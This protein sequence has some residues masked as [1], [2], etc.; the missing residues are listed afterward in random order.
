MITKNFKRKIAMSLSLVLAFVMS[1]GFLHMSDGTIGSAKSVEQDAIVSSSERLLLV[2]DSENEYLSDITIYSTAS[3]ND[4]FCDDVILVVLTRSA[5]RSFVAQS[6]RSFPEIELAEVVCLTP[7]KQQAQD[8]IAGS[9]SE[10]DS[11]FS[12]DARGSINLNYFRQILKLRLANPSREN[13]LRAVRLLEKRE[14]VRSAEP[15]FHFKSDYISEG[16]YCHYRMQPFSTNYGLWHLNRINL[17]QA[18]GITTGSDTVRVGLLSTGV[19]VAH[20]GF[21]GGKVYPVT[22]RGGDQP[23]GSQNFHPTDYSSPLTDPSGHGTHIAGTIVGETTGIAPGVRLVSLKVATGP[24]THGWYNT[25]AVIAAIEYA[26]EIDPVRGGIRI[27][28]LSL[29]APQHK[30]IVA[31]RDAI[32]VFPGLFVGAA[33]NAGVN[34]DNQFPLIRTDG[35]NNKIVVSGTMNSNDAVGFWDCHWLCLGNHN[36]CTWVQFN[37]GR[38]TVCI[39]APGRDIRSTVPAH[40][41]SSG[42]RNW[43]GTSM[44][45]PMVAGVA[46]L[47]MSVNPNLRNNPALT[48]TVITATANRNSGNLRNYSVSG[49]LVD[50][51]SAVRMMQGNRALTVGTHTTSQVTGTQLN[52]VGNSTTFNM[53]LT[54]NTGVTHRVRF[55]GDGQ[56]TRISS[57][58]WVALNNIFI[59]PTTRIT[60]THNAFTV[61]S[62][63]VKYASFGDHNGFLCSPL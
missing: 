30:N 14:D 15:N 25:A 26:S 9:F 10:R 36:L 42:Y 18:H 60:F 17:Q 8:Q 5:S 50:A 62:P 21:A 16:L 51:Y 34:A 53:E 22:P 39:F 48:R 20:S 29:S 49:G 59:F 44:S 61:F 43:M 27:P 6:T 37:Y 31:V 35:L 32:R 40:V 47:M 54:S 28:I 58:T 24:E 63:D 55:E 2:H 57:P 33:G 11:S 13:V 52:L 19:E 46:A 23:T 38:E 41:H 45:A 7:G 12:Y 3:I 56:F 4:D 1:I